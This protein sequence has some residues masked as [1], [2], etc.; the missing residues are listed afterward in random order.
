M[1][2]YAAVEGM[3]VMSDLLAQFEDEHKAVL[4]QLD[5]LE[6]ALIHLEIGEDAESYLTTVRDIHGFLTTAV[7]E[8]NDA[9]E[10][11]LFGL[12][13][14]RRL[15]ELF[16]SEHRQLRKLEFQLE[17]ELN[18]T[19]PVHGVQPVVRN[20]IDLL[21]THIAREDVFLFPKVREV[22]ESNGSALPANE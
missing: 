7:R 13:A 9:E 5:R 12:F 16:E 20:I 1:G 6:A 18:G 10:R 22:L 3:D 21:R 17:D 14:N 4:R 2:R 8:H 11:L 19:D 15:C